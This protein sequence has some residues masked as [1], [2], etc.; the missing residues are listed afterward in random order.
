MNEKQIDTLIAWAKSCIVAAQATLRRGL[1]VSNVLVV[2]GAD[3]AA[4][5]SSLVGRTNADERA[6]WIRAQVAA[7]EGEAF[8]FLSDAVLRSRD[9]GD[10]VGEAL[11]A[12]IETHAGARYLVSC[13]YTR[14]PLRFD[15]IEVGPSVWARPIFPTT[16]AH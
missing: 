1:E 15:P 16:P 10:R 4:S 8:A 13:R 12:H 5:F 7:A 11:I 14:D 3:G 9:G 6:A 2:I